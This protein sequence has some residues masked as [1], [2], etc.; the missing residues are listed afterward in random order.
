MKKILIATIAFLGVMATTTAQTGCSKYYP[1]KEGTTAEITAYDKKGE[2][3]AV[4][5]YTILKTTKTSEGEVA[6]MKS[7]VKDEKGKLIA[8]T[9]YNATCD[10]N[11]ISIDYKSMV[12]PLMMDQFKDMEYDISGTDLE[13]PNNLSVGQT[14]PDAQMIMNISMGGIKMNMELHITNRKVIGKE[15]IT[16]PAGT[17]DCFII[18]SEM[19][20]KMGVSQTSN[21]KQWLAEGVGM[22]KQEEY[23]KGKVSSSSM[24][25]AFT[26]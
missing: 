13:I 22:V 18:T 6:T 2:K 7:S 11:K 1:F 21:S 10:G 14:L 26:K 23:Q 25:T 9:E 8:E 12:S 3:S 17:F 19:T 4:I 5:D 24:L 15:N 20:T 16:T